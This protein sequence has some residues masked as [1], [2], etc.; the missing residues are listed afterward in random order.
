MRRLLVL[1]A[2]LAW[3]L[4]AVTAA[5]AQNAPAGIAPHER[6]YEQWRTARNRA[7]ALV[8]DLRSLQHYQDAIDIAEKVTKQDPS[9]V[10]WQRLLGESYSRMG[11]ALERADQPDY[12]LDFYGA[13]LK[14]TEGLAGAEA[15]AGPT[16][17]AMIGLKLEIGRIHLEQGRIAQAL[18][19]I[20]EAQA[21]AKAAVKEAPDDS[22]N[23]RTLME[24]HGWMGALQAKQGD[25][26]AALTSRRDKVAIAERLAK[27]MPGDRDRAKDL[28]EAYEALGSTFEVEG[29]AAAAVDNLRRAV[30]VRRALV[31]AEPQD[32][33]VRIDLARAYG[34]IGRI[35]LRQGELQRSLEACSESLDVLGRGHAL[36]PGNTM[37]DELQAQARA[38]MGVV[39]GKLGRRAEAQ[40]SLLKAREAI[41][42]LRALYPGFSERW[43]AYAWIDRELENLN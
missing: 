11:W 2:T 21:L 32:V 25:L 12:A 5:N 10:A 6:S 4:A 28:A 41:S 16:R 38:H 8:P 30:A 15:R 31:D 40:E 24:A 34:S 22:A 13:A 18:P 37:W 1:A 14:V 43:D 36:Q 29:S 35:L 42:A 26:I 3:M 17:R 20:S 33:P 23:Q 27:A 39:L 19:T 7:E 9:S